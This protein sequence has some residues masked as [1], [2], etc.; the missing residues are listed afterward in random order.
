MFFDVLVSNGQRNVFQRISLLAGQEG[1]WG[2]GWP[3]IP[4]TKQRGGERVIG[5]ANWGIKKNKKNILEFDMVL[6]CKCSTFNISH[7]FHLPFTLLTLLP[8]SFSTLSTDHLF[9]YFIDSNRSIQTPTGFDVY[10][11]P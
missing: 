5:G 11:F 7:S 6:L 9:N 1:G 3:Q 8:Q 2:R 10:V 4:A